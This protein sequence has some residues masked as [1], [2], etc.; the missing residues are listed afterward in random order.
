MYSYEMYPYSSQYVPPKPPSPSNRD[1][2]KSLM[3]QAKNEMG[4]IPYARK[5]EAANAHA[6]LAL[7]DVLADF[8]TEFRAFASRTDA[9]TEVRPC[10]EPFNGA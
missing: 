5:I 3:G 10:G 1:E 4:S 7:V 2:A 8:L 6:T 9:P